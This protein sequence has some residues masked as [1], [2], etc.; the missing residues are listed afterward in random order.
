MGK[1]EKVALSAYRLWNL[2]GLTLLTIIL[3]PQ[4]ESGPI[5]MTFLA[6]IQG[7]K[8]HLRDIYQSGDYSLS[9]EPEILKPN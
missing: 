3:F 7:N 2:D 5:P 6:D 4:G 1:E 9:R 8:L